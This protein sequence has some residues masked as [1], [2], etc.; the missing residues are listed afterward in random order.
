MARRKSVNV[1]AIPRIDG[2]DF[3]AAWASYSCISCGKR[4]FEKI[5]PVL[6]TPEYALD[7]FT[8]AC[9]SCGYKH[10]KESELPFKNWPK[11]LTSASGLPAERFWLG[12][13]RSATEK[14]ESYWKQCNTCAR[15]LPN[16]DF[17]RHKDWG[18]LEKQM[19]CRACKAVINTVLNE[20]RT[21]EQ[22]RESAMKRR[23]AELLV[24]TNDE[25]LDVQALFDRFD[26][27]CFKTGAPLKIE[28]GSSWQ[29]DHTLPSKYFYP[30]SKTN[31][32][33][34]SSGANQNK[35]DA[36]PSKFYTNKELIRLAQ[37]TGASLELLSRKSPV[38]NENIDVNA[39][40]DKFLNVREGSDLVKRISELKL[41]L[42]KHELSHKLSDKN[43]KL[44]GIG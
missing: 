7:N 30:L 21:P 1:T 32:T 26:H 9:E 11:E 41:I 12:F 13:F 15:I 42:D 14:A 27:K 20:L 23:I 40:V 19:E 5:G 39:C 8:W 22:L 37:I 36:W 31:A 29:I 33:L 6:I 18:P 10:S 24:A 3:K 35:S 4:N 44:L 28:E 38:I 17:S 2:L 16:S 25:K 43:K 34:L